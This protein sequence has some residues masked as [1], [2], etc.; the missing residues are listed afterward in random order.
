MT[1]SSSRIQLFMGGLGHLKPGGHNCLAV[2]SGGLLEIL[3]RF[4]L[5][6]GGPQ[7]DPCY[8]RL[9]PTTVPAYGSGLVR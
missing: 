3:E 4:P 8:E 1:D 6:E 7:G 2:F 9:I 5:A